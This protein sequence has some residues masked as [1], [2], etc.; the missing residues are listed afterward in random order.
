MSA[1]M[2]PQRRGN[3]LMITYRFYHKPASVMG[4]NIAFEEKKNKFLMYQH[5][6]AISSHGIKIDPLVGAFKIY[7]FACA[8]ARLPCP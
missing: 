1:E 7:S 5:L 6:S 2:E 8:K 3:T 4:F